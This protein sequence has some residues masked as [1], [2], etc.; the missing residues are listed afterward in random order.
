MARRSFNLAT[1]SDAEILAVH[2]D[3]VA[4]RLKYYRKDKGRAWVMQELEALD[5]PMRQM[6]KD[7]L[8]SR[9]NGTHSK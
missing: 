7:R 8:N 6:V 9:L 3:L 1:L 2:V 4:C 5:E